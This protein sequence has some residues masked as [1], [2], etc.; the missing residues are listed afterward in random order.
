MSEEKKHKHLEFIQG[1]INRLSSNS[2]SLKRWSILLVSAL[3]AFSVSSS[4]CG[5]ISIALI[6]SIIFWILDGFFLSQERRYRALY[7][8][9]RELEND[10]IDFSMNTNSFVETKGFLTWKAAIFSKTLV[11]FYGMLIASIFLIILFG[12]IVK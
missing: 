5:L 2:F 6:P 8:H 7:D 11:L 4:Q 1:V 10:K 9:V 3:L 12:P